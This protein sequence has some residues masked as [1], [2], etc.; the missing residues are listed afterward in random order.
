MP[1]RRAESSRVIL[2][3]AYFPPVEYFSIL[4]K[5]SV[6]YVDSEENYQKQSYRNRCRILTSNGVEDLR[7]PI[8]HDGARKITDIKVDYKTPW[9]RQTEYAIETAY[10]SSPF[11]EYYRDQL[12]AILDSRPGRLWDLNSALTDF[13]IRK[14]GLSVDLLPS[15]SIS[16][17]VTAPALSSAGQTAPGARAGSA[18]ESFDILQPRG[19]VRGGTV[20]AGDGGVE[21]SETAVGAVCSGA[22]LERGQDMREQIHPKRPAVMANA[23]YW[24]VFGEKFGFVPNLSIMDLLFNEGPESICYL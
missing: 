22:E 1:T 16:T 9:V 11:F 18:G 19:I 10:Y 14:I 24:Q 17:L 4:A 15:S 3:T 23:P 20:A 2:S 6:V 7:F 5:Y 8:V 13:F 12:F 21:R